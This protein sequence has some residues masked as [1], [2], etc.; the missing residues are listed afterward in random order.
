MMSNLTDPKIEEKPA[1]VQPVRMH[2]VKYE[3]TYTK[4]L[5]NFESSKV[6]VGLEQ[7][8]W[9]DPSVTFGRV[10]QWVEEN[11]EVAVKEVNEALGG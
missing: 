8:N 1:Q 9:G 2:R 11:M 3:I 5:G 7:D 4:N 10:R 6:S